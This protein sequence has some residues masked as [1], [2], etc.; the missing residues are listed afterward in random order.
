V[1]IDSGID[2][3]FKDSGGKKWRISKAY[4]GIYQESLYG[5]KEGD[6]FEQCQPR[7]N[8]IHAWQGGECPLP[9]GFRV[10][11]WRRRASYNT[12]VNLAVDL[13][14]SFRDS[15]SDIIHFEVLGLAEGYVMPWESE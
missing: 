2:C 15:N 3:E 4:K 5:T 8:H 10:K 12:S 6:F 11:V 1:L 7:M 9:E 13:D 14:W